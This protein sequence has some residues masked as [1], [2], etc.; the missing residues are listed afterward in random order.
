MQREL[1]HAHTHPLANAHSQSQLPTHKMNQWCTFIWPRR[2]TL[3]CT[4]LPSLFPLLCY[5]PLA[6]LCLRGR[7]RS[8][9]A[10]FRTFHLFP[11]V[12]LRSVF[13]QASI[14]ATIQV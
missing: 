7:C 14:S 3:P 2:R 8:L 12:I 4:L 1:Y 10:P 11:L 5:I 9:T 6:L 13:F